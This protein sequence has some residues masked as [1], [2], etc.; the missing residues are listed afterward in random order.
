[1]TEE[2]DDW[3]NYIT[4]RSAVNYILALLGGFTFT[5]M[6]VLVTSLGDSRHDALSQIVLL[7]AATILDLLI[8]LILLN[9]TTI[10][11]YVRKIPPRAALNLFSVLMVCAIALWGYL[12]PLILLLFKVTPAGYVA[13][14]EWTLI[15]L[16]GVA[17]IYGPFEKRRRT[18]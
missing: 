18:I 17:M 12:M 4:Y 5:S 13:T 15:V 9:T 10:F 16:I 6:T 8:L 11:K 1:M 2:Q 7:F 3:S 14:A